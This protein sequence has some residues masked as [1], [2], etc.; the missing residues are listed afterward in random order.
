[1]VELRSRSKA[2]KMSQKQKDLLIQPINDRYPSPHSKVEV[3]GRIEMLEWLL[4]SE[5]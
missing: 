1:M 5:S 4:M 3:Q 2:L